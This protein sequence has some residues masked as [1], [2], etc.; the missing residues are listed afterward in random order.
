MI[1]VAVHG[2][3]QRLGGHSALAAVI[4]RDS[5]VQAVTAVLLLGIT[6][7]TGSIR[8]KVARVWPRR[9]DAR[10][11]LDLND[12]E[13]P[14]DQNKSL[15]DEPQKAAET[16]IQPATDAEAVLRGELTALWHEV[17]ALRAELARHRRGNAP[18]RPRRRMRA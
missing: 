10:Q 9:A 18:T 13:P 15:L 4:L 6:S 2:L 7:V 16:L 1:A 12:S 11:A 3:T 5:G 8:S 14:I 17:I